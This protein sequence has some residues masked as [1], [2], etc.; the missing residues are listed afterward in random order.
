M[1]HERRAY[2]TPGPNRQETWPARPLGAFTA[3]I[4]IFYVISTKFRLPKSS[5]RLELKKSHVHPKWEERGGGG[6]LEGTER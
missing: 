4:E 6:H 1:A 2:A 5:K 3:A